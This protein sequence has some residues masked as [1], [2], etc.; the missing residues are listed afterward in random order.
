MADLKYTVQVD[1]K[2]AEQALATLRRSITG[3]SVAFGAALTGIAASVKGSMDNIDA[4]AKSARNLGTSFGSFQALARSAS[5]AGVS[6][7]TLT[8]SLT[9][10]Q[11]N[12]GQAFSKGTGPAVDALSKLGVSLTELS[13]LNVDQQFAR[14]TQE[15]SKIQ[16]PAERA[17]LATELLGKQGPKLLEAAAG[18]ERLKQETEQM[19]LALSAIDTTTIE[20]ANDAMSELGIIIE[21]ARNKLAAELAPFV[22]AI[23]RMFKDAAMEGGNLGKIITER[24]IPAIRLMAQAFA[25]FLALVVAGK[26]IA[27]LTIMVNTMIGMVTAIRTAT[28]AMGVFNAVAG[29]NPLVMIAKGLLSIGA[30][31]GA[32]WAVNEAF[33][34]LDE[35]VAEVKIEMANT[36][37]ETDNF[38]NA[39][40]N[41]PKVVETFKE[42]RQELQG[43]SQA[44]AQSNQQKL[45]D[46]SLSTKLIGLSKD[47]V[48]VE[49]SRADMA[50]RVSDEIGKL[51]EK[52]KKLT[53][54]QIKE[55]V[56]GVIDQQ[57]AAINELAK[58]DQ[59]R[60]EQ[61]LLGH[62]QR[63]MIQQVE[64]FQ[65]RQQISATEELI[66][67]QGQMAKLTM[68]DIEQKYYDIE[69]AAKKTARA[70]IQ[71]EEA[72]IGR[73]LDPAEQQRYYDSAL[74]GIGRLQE[75]HGKLNEM[76]RDFNIGWR[77]AV[78]TYISDSTN[79]FKQAQN[80]FSSIT[81]NMESALDRFVETGKFKFSD[82]ARSVIMDLMKIQLRAAA[83]NFLSSLMGTFG[84]AN[85]GVFAGGKVT[86][87]ANGGVVGGPTLFPMANGMGLMGE[88]GP[89]AIMPL[90]RGKDGKLGVASEG[91]SGQVVNNYYTYNISAVDAKSVAQLF[92]EN[93]R[94]LLGTI[95]QAEKELPFRG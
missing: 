17:S 25:A 13:G 5:M 79:G 57:I 81:R 2:G 86:A 41:T 28:T 56:G 63:Q 20:T 1:T 65:T 47:Q 3:I 48:D 62:N 71:A 26:L 35:K 45:N 4:M 66:N 27:T 16:D 43:V 89:E 18:M 84:F 23:S 83:S 39:G 60:T 19:G 21:N 90:K 55:G 42:L 14:I 87:F 74:E 33:D 6:T 85:G 93:R 44:F 77:Q 22:I 10:L 40:A 61:A 59:Q 51:E 72:R 68:T 53:E 30:A 64:L 15:L 24:V 38:N 50:K 36:A 46:I 69:A 82:F 29:K 12:L 32:V 94:T 31:A 73:R 70:A 52:R 78:N 91:G 88:A 8:Q 75:E 54:A 7:D 37:T 67:I 80:M 58:K 92:S 76:T 11:V 49:R 9:R 95:K 34:A